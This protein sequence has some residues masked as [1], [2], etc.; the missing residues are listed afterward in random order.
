MIKL[1]KHLLLL[2]LILFFFV[3]FE[4][5][6]AQGITTKGILLYNQ[7][8]AKLESP[9]MDLTKN[10]SFYFLNNFAMSYAISFWQ[11]N[12][13][14]YLGKFT[15][16]DSLNILLTYNTYSNT[17]TTYLQLIINNKNSSL[18][19]PFPKTDLYRSKWYNLSF[20]FD[21]NKNT[22][23][24][25]QD[26]LFAKSISVHLRE[27]N[28]LEII[29]GFKHSF[30]DQPSFAVKE[31]RISIDDDTPTHKNYY[32]PL[33]NIADN[34][35]SDR[36][37][38]REIDFK[39]CVSLAGLHDEW[40][41]Q[42]EIKVEGTSS[43]SVDAKN[44]RIFIVDENHIF[45]F[46]LQTNRTDTIF[47]K[48]TVNDFKAFYDTLS[49]NL[50][51]YHR[52]GGEVSVFNW[53]TNN[54]SI[55]NNANNSSHYYNHNTFINP[56]DSSLFIFGGYGWY[57]FRN[58][59]QKYNFKT[60]KWEIIN[61]NGERIE[62]R[63]Y[64]SPFIR[65]SDST[66]ITYGGYGNESGQQNEG[67]QYF[68]DLWQFNLKT[69]TLKRLEK[70]DLDHEEPD[71]RLFYIDAKSND[72]YFLF[73]RIKNK[74]N[75]IELFKADKD[76]LSNH[77][78]L[79]SKVIDDST[80]GISQ[81]MFH[82]NKTNEIIIIQRM[83]DSKYKIRSMLFPPFHGNSNLAS[84]NKFQIST[85]YYWYILLTLSLMFI[86]YFV[87]RKKKIK[88]GNSFNQGELVNDSNE[89]EVEYSIYFFGRF[90]LIDR[91]GE[92]KTYL[93][94]SKLNE[95][96]LLIFFHTYNLTSNN[97]SKGI[98]TNKLSTILWP[99]MSNH[100][101]KNVRNVT[102]NKLRS[103]LKE[104]GEIEIIFENGL[105]KIKVADDT[106][107]DFIDMIKII[108]NCES[109]DLMYL[110]SIAKKGKLLNNISYEW[111][112]PIKIASDNLII[113][114]L[115][116]HLQKN[117]NEIF[118]LQVADTILNIDSVNE[119]GLKMKLHV[120]NSQ[121]KHS[122][123]QTVYDN[124]RLEY[125]DLYDEEYDKSLKDILS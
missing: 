119:E 77:F 25:I 24:I 123:V 120:L 15:L 51:T 116:E 68:H 92:D 28:K 125:R 118:S 66:L 37:N 61:V 78:L 93:M 39:N 14:G 16:N 91:S 13:F 103:V 59:F 89:I 105:W 33:N 43:S 106:N 44:G 113:D 57:T 86:S 84:S 26:S 35:T 88:S 40:R 9:S 73:H 115:L 21:C 50:Y 48:T 60:K 95:M 64:I 85:I 101:L 104:I 19:I 90:Q 52:G 18:E 70:I 79:N 107:I 17:D 82:N 124:F 122:F 83:A 32:W 109:G 56:I 112:D 34:R 47:A 1:L 65:T 97:G 45:I 98:S 111:L 36:I 3:L 11:P 108:E 96:F 22:L 121:G 75:I 67:I 53:E 6:T 117:T 81:N 76:D 99:D 10:K 94:S 54:W 29:F 5:E 72:Y 4:K 58:E 71:K 100:Q 114:C 41:T 102:V 87:L 38:N 12:Y 20:N 69:F 110:I 42:T 74:K 63:T 8:K 7:R 55:I 30:S 23:E 2:F 62:P 27:V 80:F 46:N 49:N 31:L